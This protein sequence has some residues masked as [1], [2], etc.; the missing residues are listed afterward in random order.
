MK[1]I[2][3]AETAT[4]GSTGQLFHRQQIHDNLSFMMYKDRPVYIR[5]SSLEAVERLKSWRLP[6]IFGKRLTPSGLV[7]I[8]PI[9]YNGS[10]LIETPTDLPFSELD[11]KWLHLPV[12]LG[13]SPERYVGRKLVKFPQVS[14]Y[15]LLPTY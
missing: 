13:R 12:E 3:N 9:Q 4:L 8:T 2:T 7:V 14:P 6:N 15:R 10:I 11:D 1:P 5:L